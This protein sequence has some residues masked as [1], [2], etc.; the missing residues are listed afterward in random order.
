M[1]DITSANAVL[2]LAVPP[3]FP[4]PQQLQ[5]FAVDDVFDI[6]AVQSVETMMGVDG[7]LSAGFVFREIEMMIRLQADSTSNHIFDV[8]YTQQVATLSTYIAQGQIRLPAIS[9]KFTLSNGF[10]TNYKPAPSARRVLQPREF[11][12]TFNTIAPSPAS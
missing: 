12:I 3:L 7:V 1:G 4:T 2:T 6:S 5:S 8:W 9:T 11:R 10:L